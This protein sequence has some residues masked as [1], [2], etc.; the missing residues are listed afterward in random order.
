LPFRTK[1][2]LT[3]ALESDAHHRAASKGRPHGSHAGTADDSF[4]APTS[5]VSP[6]GLGPGAARGWLLKQRPDRLFAVR[7][8]LNQLEKIIALFVKALD[9]LAFVEAVNA[10][11][12]GVGE[13]TRDAIGGNS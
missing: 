3:A 10:V 6:T 4:E 13:P 7:V 11:A 12:V 1:P 5:A 8:G 9:R 2:T